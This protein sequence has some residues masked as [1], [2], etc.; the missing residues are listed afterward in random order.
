MW[1][2]QSQPLY[3]DIGRFYTILL[4]LLQWIGV[5]TDVRLRAR[6]LPKKREAIY[7]VFFKFH[8]LPPFLINVANP[9]TG[10]ME[11]LDNLAFTMHFENSRNF[12]YQVEIF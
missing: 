1:S 7:S 6:T 8:C 4:K 3:D 2:H 5:V 9:R 12:A 11:Y 10:I